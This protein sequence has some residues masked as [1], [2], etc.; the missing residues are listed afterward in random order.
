MRTY[1]LFGPALGQRR[2]P[3]T[4]KPLL[5]C[6]FF[7]P[8][9]CRVSVANTFIASGP[10]PGDTRT[11][12]TAPGLPW[13]CIGKLSL[14]HH[15]FMTATLVGPDVILTAAHG[16][17]ENGKLLPGNFIF[18]PD[19]G[20]P[21]NRSDSAA[22][23]TRIWLGSLTPTRGDCRHSDWALLR[24]DADLGDT[25][26]TLRVED[27]GNAILLGNNRPYSISSYA[28]DFRSGAAPSWQTGCGFVSLDPRGYLLHDFSTDRGASGSP[29]FYF[30]EPWLSARIVA[31][32]VAELTGHGQT[33]DGIPFSAR[34][35][36][37]AIASHE[38][39]ETL[40]EILAGKEPAPDGPVSFKITVAAPR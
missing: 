24:I 28:R 35:A 25:Y 13:R 26:G 10:F 23:V 14:P 30:P 16:L 34:T 12:V 8:L 38:F 6:L 36:N 33:L 39:F 7:W 29:I 40:Q 37:V 18:R 27:A 22:R 21:H 4:L 17:V 1:F 9:V 32:N 31:L 11:A 20:N 3:Q 2:L 5:A 19:F 15:R